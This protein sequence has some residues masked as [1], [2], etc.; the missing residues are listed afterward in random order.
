MY[1]QEQ[2]RDLNT[3][4]LREYWPEMEK[5]LDSKLVYRNEFI[6]YE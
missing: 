1:E 2:Y 5:A 6:L 4:G 3:A